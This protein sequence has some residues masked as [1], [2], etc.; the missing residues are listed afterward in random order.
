MTEIGAA[1]E[2]DIAELVP[3]MEAYCEFYR[4]P[5]P[6]E[7][8]LEAMARA[9]IQAPDSAGMIFVARPQ[10]ESDEPEKIVGFVHVT[11][12]MSLLHATRVAVMEDLYVDPDFRRRG[13]AGSLIDAVAAR[14]R[15]LGAPCLQWVTEPSNTTAQE[16]YSRTGA[17]PES[18]LE[19]ELDLRAT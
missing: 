3:L 2:S 4:W 8:E 7:E 14:A 17:Q 9:E 12:K 13:I 15:D 1:R 10:D 16:V 19:Y 6:G 11:W 5:S 18:W